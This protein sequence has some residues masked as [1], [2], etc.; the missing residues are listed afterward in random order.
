MLQV[1]LVFPVVLL[2]Y[3]LVWRYLIGF[4]KQVARNRRL[5]NSQVQPEGA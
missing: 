5:L 1:V 2:D 4:F 3:C